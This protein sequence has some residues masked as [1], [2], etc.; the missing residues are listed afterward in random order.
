[1]ADLVSQISMGVQTDAI[2]VDNNDLNNLLKAFCFQVDAA[3]RTHFNN[4][5]SL[6]S[7]PTS[8]SKTTSTSQI[9]S[10]LVSSEHSVG[11]VSFHRAAFLTT[12]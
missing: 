5:S 9:S 2:K 12:R 7:T 6:T 10:S 8:T 4:G 1:M 11:Q 3:T